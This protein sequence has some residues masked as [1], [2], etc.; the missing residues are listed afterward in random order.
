M[1]GL[2]LKRKRRTRDN[3]TL[4]SFHSVE[5]HKKVKSKKDEVKTS[6]NL[7]D[8][9]QFFAVGGASSGA[10]YAPIDRNT[11]SLEFL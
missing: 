7:H 8:R 11:V 4:S 6:R 1:R 2:E 10:R 3:E 5:G 9:D